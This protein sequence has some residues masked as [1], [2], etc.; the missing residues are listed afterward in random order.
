MKRI[1]MLS[2]HLLFSQGVESLLCREA[3]L[4]IVGRE[5]DLEKGLN[6]IRELQPDVV[7]VDSGDPTHDPTP[8]VM[9]ILRERLG[10]RIIGLNL[11]DNIVCIYRGEQRIVRGVEDL[12]E[13]IEAE[14]ISRL[15]K[16]VEE[17]NM[18]Q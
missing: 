12:L 16:E 14:P 6:R 15:N 17:L 3:G 1:F 7:I 10:T 9:R 11:Q 4:E 5:V 13:A 8:T 18:E 2:S